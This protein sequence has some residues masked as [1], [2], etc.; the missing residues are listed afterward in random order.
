MNEILLRNPTP[1]LVYHGQYKV[2]LK[3]EPHLHNIILRHRADDPGF[4]WIPREVRDLGRVS[5]MDEEEFRWSVL[6]VLRTLFL[7]NLREVP[8]MEPSVSSRG[9][10]DRLI[11]R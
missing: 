2:G 11:V 10:Q 9:S 8:D 5:S 7:P 4:I 6:R 1:V 3:S